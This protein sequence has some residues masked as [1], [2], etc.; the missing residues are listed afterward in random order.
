VVLHVAKRASSV[1]SVE[2]AA[3]IGGD[4]ILNIYEGILTA[5]DLEHFKSRLNQVT[6]VLALSLAVVDLVSEV[7]V[8]CLHQVQDGEDLTVVWDQGL[9]NSV[10]ASDESL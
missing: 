5:I 6:Q 2:H 9:A 10:R 4:H 1:I 8:L 3:L 7:D